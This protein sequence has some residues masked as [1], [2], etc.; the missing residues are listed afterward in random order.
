MFQR[1]FS[2]LGRLRQITTVVARHGLGHYMDQR[3]SRKDGEN[4]ESMHAS[5]RRFRAIL[6]DLGPTFI[7]FGQ[8]L[9]TRADLLPPG[10]A[11]VLSG[12][13]DDCPPMAPDV[14]RRVVEEGLG[15]PVDALFAVFDPVP[16]ASAS[17][18]Q[19]HRAVTHDGKEVAVK[20]QRPGMTASIV[21]D[22]DLLR[23]LAQLA[24][25]IIEESG[26]VTPRDIVEEF[27]QAILT[28]LDFE[29]EARMLARFRANALGGSAA[30][31]KIN[32][33]LGDDEDEGLFGGGGGGVGAWVQRGLGKRS[34]GSTGAASATAARASYVVPMVYPEL[35]CATVLTMDYVR[36]TRLSELGPQHDRRKIVENVVRSAFDQIFVHGLFHAD[37]HPGNVFI[38]DDNRL[39]LIDFGS[40]GQISYAM[41][42]TLVVLSISIGMRDADAVA[43]L[44]YR[45]GVPQERVLLHRLRDAIASL[46]DTYLQGQDFFSQVSAIQLLGD[47]F[48]LAA[49][50]K[51]RIPSEY[52]LV[53]RACVTMEGTIRQLDPDLH[54]LQMANRMV[55]DLIEERFSLGEL[56]ERALK[57]LL[58]A[59]DTVR[60]LPIMASQILMDLEAGKLRVQVDGSK[61]QAIARS[62]DALGVTMFM[63][64]VAGGLVVGSFFVL[65]QYHFMLWGLPVLPLVGL[66]LASMLFGGTL[67]RHYLMPK[68]RKVSLEQWFRQR[69]RHRRGR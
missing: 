35:S 9:S 13:Q 6:E 60:E 10:F 30:K 65:A 21:R 19:V 27:E 28:E 42:E 61:L 32:P 56:G 26:L 31:R 48:E 51:I 2:R 44:L 52:A 37:P 59:R 57:N 45:I 18:A 66:F 23:Y 11:E 25:N 55:R 33:N 58:L 15:Q 16:V 49:R 22:T 24:E 7:K 68:M 54:V 50:F 5:A 62:I 67:G 41:R 53:G 36:G 47:L 8:V 40:V 29:H 20:V 14:A 38:L 12:L 43:R 63:G 39:A 69:R 64:L 1:A 34:T 46:F 3:R 17:I 4:P